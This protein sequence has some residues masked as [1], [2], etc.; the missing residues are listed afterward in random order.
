NIRMSKS[1]SPIVMSEYQYYEF[2]AIDRPLSEKEQAEVGSFSSRAEVTSTRAVF[3]YNYSDF[4]G[5]SLKILQKYFDA[6]L[7]LTNWGTKQLAF[8]LPRSLVDA[9]ALAVYRYQ[10][11]I[12]TSVTKNHIILDIG[13]H[14]EEGS[15]VEG[16]GWLS[17]LA[18]LRRDIL[19]GDYR[20][21]Y[22]AWLK[23]IS[24]YDEI[25]EY[26]DPLEP[27]IP[28]GLKKLSA[29]LK[30][31][32]E[33][34]EIDDDLVAVASEASAANKGAVALDIERQIV[35]L[36]EQERLAFLVKAARG[37][38]QVN[39]QLLKKLKELAS[40]QRERSAPSLTPRRKAAE[41]LTA[42]AARFDRRKE[43][44]RQKA[45]KARI[46]RLNAMAQQEPEMWKQVFD[47]IKTKQTKAYDQADQASHRTAR[48]GA[49]FPP[50]GGI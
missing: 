50:V 36:S 42:A 41:L 33:F 23:A 21:L 47:L 6:M 16:E 11:L 46:K 49:T 12:S 26:G 27:P 30:S 17:S 2:Q 44:E 24:I 10:D 39:V 3:I 40:N 7:Y 15:W 13:L 32:V 18:M 5:D 25:E 28:A 20:A 22:L 34:F 19:L 14:E 4:P 31:L 43:Q 35:K 37:D 45:D 8:R 1:D 29:P 48:F 9:K 38:P